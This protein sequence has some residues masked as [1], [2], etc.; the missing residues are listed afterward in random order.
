M[1]NLLKQGKNETRKAG[2]WH[3]LVVQWVRIHLPTQWTWVQSLVR[4]DPTSLGAAE[5]CATTPEVC[6][7]RARALQQ[8]KP[9]Q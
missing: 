2:R 5:P 8:G 7:S 6:V 4:E 1:N 3:F 9:P